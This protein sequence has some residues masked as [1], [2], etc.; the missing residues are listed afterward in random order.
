MKIQT[1]VGC[2]CEDWKDLGPGIPALPKS[3]KTLKW[4]SICS[5]QGVSFLPALGKMATF[6]SAKGKKKRQISEETEEFLRHCAVPLLFYLFLEVTRVTKGKFLAISQGCWK[7]SQA[8]GENSQLLL[9]KKAEFVF[10]WW[11]VQCPR[12]LSSSEFFVLGQSAE[13]HNRGI[14]QGSFPWRFTRSQRRNL[15]DETLCCCLWPLDPSEITNKQ[16]WDCLF[17]QSNSSAFLQCG[18]SHIS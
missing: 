5:L 9:W 16:G 15:P 4:S 17:W 12:K 8:A 6:F 1:L 3:S 11:Q 13:K 10:I 2:L 18:G 7:G 14:N